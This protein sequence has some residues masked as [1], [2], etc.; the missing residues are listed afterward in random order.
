MIILFLLMITACSKNTIEKN[1]DIPEPPSILGL[2]KINNI[3]YEMQSGGYSWSGKQGLESFDVVTDHDG[4]VQMAENF[5]AITIDPG[6]A[7]LLELNASPH[8]KVY[9]HDEE[10]QEEINI[11]ENAITASSDKGRHI[12]EVVAKWYSKEALQVLKPWISGEVSYT[13]VVEVQ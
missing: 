1:D 12:Y 9:L 4:P 13:F 10:T 8:L 11:S 7:I 5:K 6:E 2:F 3:E